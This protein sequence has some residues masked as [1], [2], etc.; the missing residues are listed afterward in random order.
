MVKQPNKGKH[1]SGARVALYVDASKKPQP[2]LARAKKEP[3][4]IGPAV[5]DSIFYIPGVSDCAPSTGDHL[6]ARDRPQSTQGGGVSGSAC[7]GVAMVFFH[8]LSLHLIIMSSIH[9]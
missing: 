7:K 3:A 5:L 6:S 1:A 8:F 2:D 4:H 9:S